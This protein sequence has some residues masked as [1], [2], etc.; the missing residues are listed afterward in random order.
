VTPLQKSWWRR[1]GTGYE[2]Q[3]GAGRIVRLKERSKAT[4]W[5]LYINDEHRGQWRTLRAT[6]QRALEMTAHLQTTCSL[7]ARRQ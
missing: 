5:A 7:N 2:Q 6:K 3:D 1:V 4:A